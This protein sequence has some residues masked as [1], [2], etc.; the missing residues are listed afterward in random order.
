MTPSNPEAWPLALEIVLAIL[1]LDLAID[2]RHAL[3]RAVH[4]QAPPLW[5]PT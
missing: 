4:C 1:L 2:L 3:L 5:E